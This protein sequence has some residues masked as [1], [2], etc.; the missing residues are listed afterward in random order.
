MAYTAGGVMDLS[1]ALLNDAAKSMFSYAVQLPFL[2]LAQDELDI[3]LKDCGV[4]LVNQIADIDVAAEALF[5]TLPCNFFLPIKLEERADGSTDDNAWVEMEEKD[6][7]PNR[8][9]SDTLIYWTF[10]NNKINFVGATAAREVRLHY[11]RNLSGVTDS[12]NNEEV[13]KAR[14]FLCM[15]TAALCAE[16][17]LQDIQRATSLNAQA[18]I[19]IGKLTSVLIKNTQG[20]R[21]RRRPF[22]IHGRILG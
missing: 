19:N 13:D 5:L 17:I 9:M 16:F 2:K 15:R 1:A 18:Q 11:I 10:R 8:E 22:R 4:A 7:E 12:S 3:E 21:V 6:W 14:N 20:V